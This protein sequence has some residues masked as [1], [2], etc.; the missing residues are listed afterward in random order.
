MSGVNNPVSSVMCTW[1]TGLMLRLLA[2]ICL[3]C[4]LWMSVAG[5]LVD[6]PSDITSL[7]HLLPFK[8]TPYPTLVLPSSPSDHIPQ[9][10][11]LT[12]RLKT[13]GYSFPPIHT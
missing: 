12:A 9:V 3:Y 8:S 2:H 11:S 10:I 6:L 13:S 1:V 4:C 7:S 5:V